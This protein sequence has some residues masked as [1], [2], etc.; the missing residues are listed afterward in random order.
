MQHYSLVVLE[1]SSL[2][3][4]CIQGSFSR[5]IA[6]W[7]DSSLEIQGSAVRLKGLDSKS[8]RTA[9]QTVESEC[10]ISQA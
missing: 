10:E 3:N 5:G 4:L 8:H 7:R 6:I 2:G 1:A 9:T